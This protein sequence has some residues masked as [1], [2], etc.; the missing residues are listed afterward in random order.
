LAAL[1]SGIDAAKASSYRKIIDLTGLTARFAGSVIRNFAMTVRQRESQRTVGPIAIVAPSTLVH[2]Q[3][4]L[5]AKEA[6]VE[7][8]IRVFHEQDDARR[9]LDG[10]YA[11]ESV[12]RLSASPAP[13]G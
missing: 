1:L 11:F 3:A 9:W 10:F 6:T 12:R 4:T 2:G 8:L 13:S 5:F 7:R